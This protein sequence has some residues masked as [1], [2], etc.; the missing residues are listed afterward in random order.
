[1]KPRKCTDCI[2]YGVTEQNTEEKSCNADTAIMTNMAC[3]IRRL[4]WA[5]YC[6]EEAIHN[7]TEA[8]AEEDADD[9]GEWRVPT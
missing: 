4:L 2:H 5:V 7:Q 1:M 6:L 9:D 3:L 8:L